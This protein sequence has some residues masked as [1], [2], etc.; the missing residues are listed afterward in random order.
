MSFPANEQE[1]QQ[2]C[3]NM[4]SSSDIEYEPT[5]AIRLTFDLSSVVDIIAGIIPET[6]VTISDANGK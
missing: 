4:S 2:L 5:E 6:V 1:R 3:F